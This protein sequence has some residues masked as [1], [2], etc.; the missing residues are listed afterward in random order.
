M[1]Q[2]KSEHS[3]YARATVGFTLVAALVEL[4]GVGLSEAA[5]GASLFAASEQRSTIG[6]TG[7]RMIIEI[8]FSLGLKRGAAG[9]ARLGSIVLWFLTQHAR[10]SVGRGGLSGIRRIGNRLIAAATDFTWAEVVDPREAH[11]AKGRQEVDFSW[12]CHSVS[13]IVSD[14]SAG[15]FSFAVAGAGAPPLINYLTE[16]VFSERFLLIEAW[17]LRVGVTA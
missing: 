4:S 12:C 10:A 13:G 9:D 1:R 8:G 16:A 2:R 7:F 5:F 14:N 3:E 11:R 15:A 17:Q 6:A